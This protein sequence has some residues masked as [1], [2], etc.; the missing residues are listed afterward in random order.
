M[1]LAQLPGQIQVTNINPV[2]RQ[3]ESSIGKQDLVAV[4]DTLK[5][6][7]FKKTN[8]FMPRKQLI[9][10]TD[11][12]AITQITYPN[13]STNL[14][15]TSS[16][17]FFLTRGS[18]DVIHGPLAF[19]F[20]LTSSSDVVLAPPQLWF[21]RIEVFFQGHTYK[22]RTFYGDTM[23]FN[24]LAFEKYGR[25]KAW[26]RF[27]NMSG[28]LQHGGG[29]RD[30][31]V[32]QLRAN[33][34]RDFFLYIPDGV[35]EN[36]DILMPVQN[37]D[38]RFVFYPVNTSGSSYCVSGTAANV[39]CTEMALH[40]PEEHLDES[41]Y[42]AHIQTYRG[43]IFGHSY[44]DNQQ[45]TQLTQTTFTAGSTVTIDLTNFNGL[46]NMLLC[47]FRNIAGPP[48]ATSD[49]YINS[50]TDLGDDCLFD[51][52]ENN[53]SLYGNGQAVKGS[54]LRNFLAPNAGFPNLPFLN[55]P[56]Y[57]IIFSQDMSKAMLGQLNGYMDFN[58]FKTKK[59]LVITLP[60]AGTKEVQRVTQGGGAI[61][62]GNIYL[63]FR[64]EI[65]QPL[66][67][68][69][70]TSTLATAFN[71]LPSMMKAGLTASF[72]S[73]FAAGATVDITFTS[74]GCNPVESLVVVL[75]GVGVATA[76]SFTTT[77]QTA[78]IPGFTSA[79]NYSVYL[80]NYHMR[81]IYDQDGML[82]SVSLGNDA[83][84]VF[85]Y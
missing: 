1:S 71:A 34:T 28:D 30:E 75:P 8:V 33:T 74:Q 4:P 39:T 40:V 64:G 14:L 2:F 57:P 27:A 42:K 61:S 43:K 3:Q 47:V 37:Q 25:Q 53:N 50:I 48:V 66:A 56:Y 38:I 16:F 59:S 46:S 49:Q 31:V 81:D 58:P 19:R 85:Q 26:A 77:L 6:G 45:I 62:A 76:T 7:D 22:A 9:A 82:S 52:K 36:T 55:I 35:F 41:D 68:N 72:G 73:T 63:A 20:R 21:D 13:T 12:L 17:E 70:S 80:Y 44:I 18:V 15:T 5:R 84:S 10:H 65:T 78:A 32:G 60:S 67:F 24:S 11:P 54:L 83:Q 23:Y 29:R 69:A 79:S 51:I